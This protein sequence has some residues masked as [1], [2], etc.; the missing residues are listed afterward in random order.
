MTEV[1]TNERI[2]LDTEVRVFGTVP[3]LVIVLGITCGACIAALG[4]V[5]AGLSFTAAFVGGM[6]RLYKLDPRGLKV[7]I[8]LLSQ[9]T[10]RISATG[11]HCKSFIILK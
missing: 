5:I 10:D 9:N 11:R 8:K 6:Y 3:K 1:T 4:G 2:D 7:A